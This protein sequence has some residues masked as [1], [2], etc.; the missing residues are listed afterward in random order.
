MRRLTVLIGAALA[1]FG[2]ALIAAVAYSGWSADRTAVTREHQ[3][4]EN[5]LD[6]AVSRV[7]DEQKSIA[8]WD[9]AVVNLTRG[10][11]NEQ[12]ADVEYGA[13]LS[14]TYHH[15]DVFVLNAND[16]PVYAY[17]EGVRLNPTTAY[18][19]FRD[20]VAQLVAEARSGASSMLPRARAFGLKQARAPV[21]LGGIEPHWSAHIVAV[22][23]SPAIVSVMSIIPNA[24]PR[25][26]RGEPYLLVSV[27]PVNDAFMHEL[28]EGLLLPDLRHVVGGQATMARVLEP[29]ATDD[30]AASGYLQW[31]T[32]QP[33]KVLLTFI[34]PLVALGVLAAGAFT[35]LMIRRLK[36][37]STQLAAREADARHQASHDALCDV[38]NRRKFSALL[39][40]ELDT[41]VVT[42]GGRRVAIACIDIDRFKDVND[43]MGHHAGDK[44]VRAVAE[45]LQA[46]LGPQD[47]LARFGGDEFAVMRPCA[48]AEDAY[49]LA[50][51][52]HAALEGNFQLMDQSIAVTASIG[53]AQAPD[54][55]CSSDELIRAADIA[56]YQAKSQGR[57]RS[58]FF[59][60]EMAKDVEQ[61]REIEVELRAAIENDTLELYYQPLVACSSGRVTTLEALLRWR[62][63]TRGEI[64]PGVFVPIAEEAG[65]MPALGAWV[66]ERAF[67]DSARWPGVELAVNLSPVQFR[68]V[69]LAHT[70]RSLALAYKIEPHRFLF[71]VTEGVLLES[72]ERNR[73]I[74]DEIRSAG[75]KIALDDFGTG[76][77]SL[78]YLADF[79][80]DKIKI[81]RAF[82]TGIS[83][84]KR[85]MTIIQSIV[86]L[87]R[88]LGMD[89]VAEGVET[90]AEASAMRLLG[91]TQLQGFYFSRPVQSA[92]VADLLAS[93]ERAAAPRA[94]MRPPSQ[95]RVS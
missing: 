61:R 16:A 22:N 49:A 2:L 28:G 3:L 92:A 27:V 13:F 38:P 12:W 95:I 20:K 87:G 57:A 73:A 84:R 58:M 33:G 15:A 43:T 45:R 30:G 7:L 40:Q 93:F 51:A 18:A 21:Q 54:H 39:Q 70:L 53:I 1:C 76:Y 31:T 56:L 6:N 68:H 5:A 86:T 37:A 72:S 46:R 48:R 67:Q 79:R 74:L 4:V 88:G 52:L 26:L 89:I 59:C 55:G 80:F 65:L 19:P 94:D 14:E 35:A 64:S 60:A 11:V 77:S 41:L 32:K 50:D 83:E 42:R 90:E 17:V 63:P 47:V 25:L 91:V 23:G 75:F 71:E 78:R 29:F 9:D 44:L 34:L 10:K 82:V 81:D 85:A 66:I 69:D 62:H 8:W 24:T 36:R